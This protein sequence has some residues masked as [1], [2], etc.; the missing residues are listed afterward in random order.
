[1]AKPSASP[2]WDGRGV[3]LETLNVQWRE[4]ASAS[5]WKSLIASIPFKSE[6]TH[7]PGDAFPSA[8]CYVADAS[9]KGNR[10]IAVAVHD[11][12]HDPSSGRS[13]KSSKIEAHWRLDLWQGKRKVKPSALE[14]S[15]RL[16]GCEGLLT[17]IAEC[18]PTNRPLPIGASVAYVLE[19]KRYKV[20]ENIR[21]IGPVP[22]TIGD[23][24]MTPD[25]TVWRFTVGTT[26]SY[27]TIVNGA[28]IKGP[29]FITWSG[30]HN[31][32]ISARLLAEVDEWAWEN[33]SQILV[34][35]KT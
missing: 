22:V 20:H 12:A 5:E 27:I 25:A 18:W 4:K 30:T 24:Q 6:S 7:E 23:I 34:E 17:R 32:S 15:V 35:A 33:I 8:T 2:R 9:E 10:R 19:P 31:F 14:R 16:G 28:S 26:T 11:G 29:E 21:T 3:S 13:T 1:V